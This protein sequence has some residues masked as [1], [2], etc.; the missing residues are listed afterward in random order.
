MFWSSLNRVDMPRSSRSVE[1]CSEL[2]FGLFVDWAMDDVNDRQLLRVWSRRLLCVLSVRRLRSVNPLVQVALINQL[3]EECLVRRT[4]RGVVA[5]LV[6]VR[7]LLALVLSGV[8]GV[9]AELSFRPP[10]KW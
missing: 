9:C 10:E 1:I 3:F 5:E 7:A 8:P 2:L 6:V 4:G